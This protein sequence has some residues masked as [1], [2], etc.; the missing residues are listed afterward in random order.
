MSEKYRNESNIHKAAPLV[1]AGELPKRRTLNRTWLWR[2][3]G[4][5][6][7]TMPK[8]ISPHAG[9]KHRCSVSYAS[10]TGEKQLITC[11]VP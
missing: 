7:N 6:K 3:G 1:F 4:K 8:S 2:E 5:K 11:P 10:P 9:P